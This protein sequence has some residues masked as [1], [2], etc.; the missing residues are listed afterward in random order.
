M[1]WTHGC[2]LSILAVPGPSII[3]PVPRRCNLAYLLRQQLLWPELPIPG[4]DENCKYPPARYKP[5]LDSSLL[6][7]EKYIAVN[8]ALGGSSAPAWLVDAFL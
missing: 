5:L 8:P 1:S 6:V 7:T 2:T 3:L 4:R